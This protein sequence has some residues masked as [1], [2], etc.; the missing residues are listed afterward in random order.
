MQKK[1]VLWDR[2]WLSLLLDTVNTVRQ[3]QPHVLFQH[4]GILRSPHPLFTYSQSAVRIVGSEYVC[5]PLGSVCKCAF[6]VHVS[7]WKCTVTIARVCVC[8]CVCRAG[9]GSARPLMSWRREER[10]FQI[11]RGTR[12]AL[13]ACYC[14]HCTNGA[15]RGKCTHTC[16]CTCTCTCTQ[17]MPAY[18]S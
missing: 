13:P 11:P 18:Q 1:K 6:V 8:V 16:T 10:L 2:E 4:V 17:L 12:I 3:Q 5:A 7:I 14:T 9:C 15:G